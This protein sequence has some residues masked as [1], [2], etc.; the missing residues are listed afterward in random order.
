MKSKFLE[1]SENI[2]A[3]IIVAAL[4]LLPIGAVVWWLIAPKSGADDYRAKE[5]RRRTEIHQRL[6]ERQTAFAFSNGAVWPD[7][8]LSTNSQFPLA[9]DVQRQMMPGKPVAFDIFMPDVRQE[10]DELFLSGMIMAAVELEADVKIEPRWLDTV[11][12]NRVGTVWVAAQIDSVTP[13][14]EQKTSERGVREEIIY[15]ASGR[16]VGIQIPDK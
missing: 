15:R 3:V 7:L 10:K 9:V 11:R 2:V 8:I 14:R 16:A 5:E 6:I 13:R 4:W 1:I 12:T